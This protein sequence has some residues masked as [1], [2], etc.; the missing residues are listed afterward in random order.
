MKYTLQNP[1][2]IA[3]KYCL[4][5]QKKKTTY[6]NEEMNVSVKKRILNRKSPIHTETQLM[7][8][9]NKVYFESLLE[10]FYCE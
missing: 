2:K 7:N 8:N 5:F 6:T 3:T 1:I 10:Y 4:N 9:R